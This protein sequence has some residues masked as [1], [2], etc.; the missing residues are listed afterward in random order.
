[1]AFILNIETST[2]VC[3]VCL[4]GDGFILRHYEN[5]TGPNHAAVLSDYIYECISH[6]HQQNIKLDAIAVSIGPGSYTGLRI[7]L[8]EAK[9]LTYGLKIPLIGVNTLEI[10]AV[11]SMFNLIDFNPESDIFQPMIDAR[12]NEVYTQQFDGS[13]N[14]LTSPQA[15]ILYEDLFKNI[16]NP[17]RVIICGNGTEKAKSILKNDNILFMP[18]IVPLAT[19]MMPLSERA[20]M[21]KEFIDI[22]Y[23]I[24]QY[25]KEFRTT[26]PKKIF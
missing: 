26:S 4:T 1:M 22:A 3:S 13:L 11:E 23:S 5:F 20:F 16:K 24:P 7:G 12:R 21:N 25:L 19:S 6:I 2:D 9:G 17:K 14:P 10:L 8:S 15:L 18:A